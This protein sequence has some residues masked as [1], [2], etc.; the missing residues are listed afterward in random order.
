MAE[1]SIGNGMFF[2]GANGRSPSV[3]AGSKPALKEN[4]TSFT[5]EDTEKDNYNSLG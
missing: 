1:G 5:T 2:V 4:T 3:G